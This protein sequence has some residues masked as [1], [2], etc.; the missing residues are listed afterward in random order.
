M[1][2]VTFNQVGQSFG[3]FDVFVNAGGS[4]EPGARIGLV[5]PNGIGKTTLLLLLTG[6]EKPYAGTINRAEGL[7]IGYLRQE[8]VQAFHDSTHSIWEEMLR[9]F[10]GVQEMESH[11]RELELAMSSEVDSEQLNA[12]LAEYG[13]LQERFEAIGGYDFEVRIKSTLEGLGF[14]AES[15]DTPLNILSGGQKTRALLARL[16]LERPDLLVLDEPTN[17][18]DMRAVEWLEH[19]LRNWQGSLLIVSHDRYFLDVVADTIWEMSRAGI[20]TYRGNYSAYLRQRQERWDRAEKVYD[21]EMERLFKELDYIKKNIDRDATNPQAVGRLRRLSREL[22]AIQEMGLV[23]YSNTKKWI[24]TGI[25]GVRPYTRYEAEDVLKRMRSPNIRPPKL[26]LRMKTTYRS[27]ELVLR[28]YNLSVG[29]PDKPLFEMDKIVLT[30]GETAALIGGNGTGKTT[31]LKTLLGEHS[32]LSGEVVLGAGLK[33]GYFAQAHDGLDLENTVLD[34]LL[35]HKPMGIGAARNFLAQY[36]FRADD[37]YKK[38]GMLSGGERGKLALAILALEGANFLLLDEPTNHLDI[39]AQEVLQEVLEQFEGTILLV[40]HDRY[41]ID[42]LATQVWALDDGDLRVYKGA[43]QAYVEARD[44][45]RLAQRE[46]KLEAKAVAVMKA[47]PPTLGKTN[48]TSAPLKPNKRQ[49]EALAKVEAQIHSVEGA[50]KELEVLI[51]HS[52]AAQ[53]VADVQTLGVEYAAQ[54][55]ALESLLLQWAGLAEGG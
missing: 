23:A 46:M 50:L 40:S 52:S 49:Q 38:V 55:A 45:E 34:E 36:L 9:P 20:E 1:A 32:Q 24:D 22:V 17:H 4:I 43:Y 42:R 54:Q 2:I 44:A 13:A 47:L 37:V 15:Y 30:R 39:P 25:G 33:I 14:S 6:L 8:A 5:G 48:G 28:T 53:K 29:Y 41:L 27:G 7:R 51:E 16:L 3:A 10:E 35:R 31:L 26:T 21:Q 12:I 18:L 19:T 11:L